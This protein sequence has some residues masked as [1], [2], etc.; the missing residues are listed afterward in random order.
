MSMTKKIASLAVYL[1]SQA[2]AGE[3]LDIVLDSFDTHTRF[4]HVYL[5]ESKQQFRV[6]LDTSFSGLAVH[7]HKCEECKAQNLATYSETEPLN[8][9]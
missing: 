5:G 8:H 1:V 4:A 3:Y 7:S 9:K 2:R 6:L